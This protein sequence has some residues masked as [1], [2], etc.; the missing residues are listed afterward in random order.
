MLEVGRI[1]LL[2]ALMQILLRDN[3]AKF[4][5]N[6]CLTMEVF[7]EKTGQHW[8]TII[9]LKTKTLNKNRPEMLFSESLYL[10]WNKNFKTA[11]VAVF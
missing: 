5:E 2:K 11:E 6:C 4:L 7:L 3:T 1:S 8:F 10:I 9:K